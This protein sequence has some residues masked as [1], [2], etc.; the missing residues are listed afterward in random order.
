MH[1]LGERLCCF[2]FS[3]VIALPDGNDIDIELM[4]ISGVQGI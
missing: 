2:L 1:I 3:R 4:V